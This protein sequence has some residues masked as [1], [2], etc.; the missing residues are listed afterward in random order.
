[1]KCRMPSSCS[2]IN[3]CFTNAQV[4][5][6]FWVLDLGPTSPSVFKSFLIQMLQSREDLPNLNGPF[7]TAHKMMVCV[8]QFDRTSPIP[9]QSR[10]G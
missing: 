1:M 3:K 10:E 9:H 8:L 6:A 2:A 7:Q 4:S 5:D